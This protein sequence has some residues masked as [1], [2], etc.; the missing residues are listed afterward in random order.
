[1]FTQ[2]DEFALLRT[3]ST[4]WGWPG[5]NPFRYL[6]PMGRWGIGFGGS[7]QL[8]FG[9]GFG[10]GFGVFFD[11]SG[12]SSGFYFSYGKGI[13]LGAS[14]GGNLTYAQNGAAFWGPS[15]QTSITTELGGGSIARN[16]QTHALNSVG[17]DWG[18][19]VAAMHLDQNTP[20]PEQPP[21]PLPYDPKAGC[22]SPRDAGLPEC[23]S[24]EDE[25]K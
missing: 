14:V 6:D 2:G 13:G 15:K 8:G 9:Y 18:L 16:P 22:S 5:Q 20:F 4:L 23:K 25:C 11:F 1:V 7:G 12:D 10:V 24:Q 21:N 19:G 3:D 17:L